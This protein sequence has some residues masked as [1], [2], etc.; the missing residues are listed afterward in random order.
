MVFMIAGMILLWENVMGGI[1][2]S[3]R[4]FFGWLGNFDFFLM[5]AGTF[6][7]ICAE[8][9]RQYVRPK[10]GGTDKLLMMRHW[11]KWSC[12]AVLLMSE[13]GVGKGTRVDA[14]RFR[15]DIKEAWVLIVANYLVVIVIIG[16]MEIRH[17]LLMQ[18]EDPFI[19]HEHNMTIEEFEQEIHNGRK[20]VLLDEVVLDVGDY[21]NYHPGGKFVIA[22]N[23]GQDISK[24]FYGGYALEG[25]LGPRPAAGW[26]HSN[27]AR[28][29]VNQLVVA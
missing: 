26:T 5:L 1:K 28:K 12:W 3:F 27:Y 16:A 25:N 11:H 15:N 13:Y 8:F 24:F 14:Y 6:L 21:V 2:Y 17:Q 7:G 10:W 19:K 22:H 4:G 20:L 23:V 18:Q 29:I 9:W